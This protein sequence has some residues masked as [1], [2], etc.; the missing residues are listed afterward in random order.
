MEELI[1]EALA[2]GVTARQFF[3]DYG[4]RLY[5][6][7][8]M[9]FAQFLETSLLLSFEFRDVDERYTVKCGPDFFEV[10]DDEMVDFPQATVS[11]LMSVWEDVKP[12]L[13][14]LSM[15]LHRARQKHEN[16]DEYAP[17][18]QDVL[19]AFERFDGTIALEILGLHHGSCG[20]R[21]FLNDYVEHQGAPC[22]H[23][24]MEWADVLAMASGDLKPEHARGSLR[25]AGDVKFGANLVGFFSN[26][27]GA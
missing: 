16:R 9:L 3:M 19:A 18:T 8:K 7:Q 14:K 4:A 6:H 26:H 24:V 2:P 25:L 20:V 15:T 27:L 10:E 5:E 23:I 22:L 17:L 1:R 13:M 12:D 11:V 21:I